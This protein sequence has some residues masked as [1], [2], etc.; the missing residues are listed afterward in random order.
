MKLLEL[1][2]DAACRVQGHPT[3]PA[4]GYIQII[5]ADNKLLAQKFER[6]EAHI[7]VLNSSLLANKSALTARQKEVTAL[8]QEK[9]RYYS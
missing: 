7:A 9:K 4:A 6:A 1:I 2:L 5:L 3:K 8:T